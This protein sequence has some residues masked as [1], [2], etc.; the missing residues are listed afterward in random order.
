M[1]RTVSSTFLGI[2]FVLSIVISAQIFA[3][4][5]AGEN[6]S[7]TVEKAQNAGSGETKNYCIEC[8][9]G[10]RERLKRPVHAW[11]NSVHAA[12]GNNCNLCHGGSSEINDKRKAKSETFK[13]TGKPDKLKVTDFCGRDGCHLIP[14]RHFKQ[15]PHFKSV[16]ETN[17]PNCTDCHGVH[18]IQRSSRDIITEKT[19]TGCHPAEYSKDII[20]TIS[21][22]ETAIDEID[23]N[24][25]KL[26]KSHIDMTNI[27]KELNTTRHEFHEMVHVFSGKIMKSS[28]DKVK[29]RLEALKLKS[30]S[31]VAIVD[32]LKLLYILLLVFGL[33]I[34]FIIAIYSIVMYSRR[35]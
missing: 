2:L 32:R 8:H 4:E 10:L 7:K 30:Q 22:F 34:I 13:F 23:N 17:H 28:K 31:K 29:A 15:G 11:R 21:V 24:I 16:Q 14:L 35:R 25:A 12:V 27:T 3:Q 6:E 1:N 5:A 26:N 19:C 20:N 18:N 9:S 33:S